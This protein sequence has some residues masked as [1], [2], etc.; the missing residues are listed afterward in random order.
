LL[1]LQPL[2][3]S[4]RHNN[5]LGSVYSPTIRTFNKI[6]MQVSQA[7]YANDDNI[8]V[9]APTGIG[10]MICAEFALLRLE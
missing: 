9:S 4:S 2:P 8:F 1:D 7:L 6:Q 5:E 10:K 3:L